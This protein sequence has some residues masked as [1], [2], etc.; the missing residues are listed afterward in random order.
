MRR[1]VALGAGLT[2]DEYLRAESNS[3]ALLSRILTGR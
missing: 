3:Q 1:K 2:Q